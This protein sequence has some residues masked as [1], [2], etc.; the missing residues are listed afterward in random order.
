MA[1]LTFTDDL[2]QSYV[3]MKN[4]LR[5]H[6]RGKKILIFSALM[7]AM[8]FL[9]T[10]L[11]YL[12]GGGLPT[13]SSALISMYL[14]FSSILALLAATLFTSG[15]IVSEF[16]E[17]TALILFTRPIK[18]WS[19][20]LGK[21][22]ASLVLG[23]AFMGLFYAIVA[24]IS[25][26]MTGV[27]P[28]DL[29]VSLMLLCAYVVGASGIAMMISAIMKKSSTSAILTFVTLLMLISIV[30]MVLQQVNVNTWF[31]IDTASASVTYCLSGIREMLAHIGVIIPAPNVLQDFSVMVV[32]G[33]VTAV[34]AFFIFRKREF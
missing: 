25:A 24:V 28:S 4:E 20:F 22:A 6:L 13:D 33:I 31:M 1:E 11:P 3:V 14:G 27:V 2:R 30:T 8:I 5:K 18:K 34:I 29:I 10:V 7:V 9:I 26:V 32:W 21:F 15:T 19:I 12:V 16:E 17:R 23:I